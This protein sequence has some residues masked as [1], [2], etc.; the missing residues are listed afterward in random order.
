M[1]QLELIHSREEL[2]I[3][4]DKLRDAE[5]STK[6]VSQQL[7]IKTIEANDLRLALDA[8]DKTHHVMVRLPSRLHVS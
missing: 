2:K 1:F 7:S 6:N 3:L 8:K 5:W 4:V